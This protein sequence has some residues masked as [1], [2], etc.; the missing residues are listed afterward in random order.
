MRKC[1][2][3]FMETFKTP[4]KL[5]ACVNLMKQ[6][7]CVKCPEVSEGKSV[8]YSVLIKQTS[9]VYEADVTDY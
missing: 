8:F 9:A 1:I 2:I 6:R 7:H 5:A 4:K 3:S